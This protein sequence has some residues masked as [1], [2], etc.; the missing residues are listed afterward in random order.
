MK[1]N[2]FSGLEVLSLIYLGTLSA[3]MED[4]VQ[5]LLG[6]YLATERTHIFPSG[7]LFIHKLYY[8][9]AWP[10]LLDTRA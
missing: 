9:S 3:P 2:L 7:E 1:E 5:Y 6:Q 4:G 10:P 8:S